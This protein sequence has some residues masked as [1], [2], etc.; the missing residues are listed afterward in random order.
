[1]TSSRTYLQSITDALE[2]VENAT[3]EEIEALDD[4]LVKEVVKR[5]KQVLEETKKGGDPH[6][7]EEHE[8]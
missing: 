7:I 1:M 8:A 4:G 6:G 3:Q 5:T 2:V